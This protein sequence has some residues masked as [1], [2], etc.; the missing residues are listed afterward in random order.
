MTPAFR[1][2]AARLPRPG[3]GHSPLA[4]FFLVLVLLF[5]ALPASAQG[6]TTGTPP[7][8]S[9]A[10][11]PD[12]INIANLNAHIDVPV[13]NKPGRGLNFTYDLSYDSS[14]W[15]PVGAS[16]SQTWQPTYNFGWRGQ[17]EAATGYISFNATVTFCYTNRNP[18]GTHIVLTNWAYHGPWGDTHTFVGTATEN[19]GSCGTINYNFSATATDGSGYALT[20]N[21]PASPPANV[22]TSAGKLILPPANATSGAGSGTDRNGNEIT[23][24]SGGVFTDTLGTTAL[25]VAGTAPSPTTFTYTAPS[26]ASA[27]Y[28]MKY[29]ALTIQT[30]FA[31]SGITDYGPTSNDLVTEIDLPDIAVNP[32]DKYTFTYEPTPGVSGNVT[33]RL[34]SV[35]L[36]TGGKISYTYTGGSN[37][38]V[39]ADGS[40]AGMQ[41][42]TPDTGNSIYWNYARTAG[43]GAAYITT[44]TDPTGNDTV[45][46]FQGIYETER[47]V[48][49]GS[50]TSGTLLRSWNTCYNAS[51]SPCTGTAITLPITQRTVIDQY[52]SAGVQCKHN[53]LYNSV[54][55][56]TEQDDYDYGPSAPGALLRK[57]LITFA[58]LSNIT[59]F[60]QQVTVQNGA[61]AIVAQTNY[62]YDETT[63]TATSGVAQHIS[64][65]GSR[66]NL[67]SINYPVSGLT[68]HFTYYDTGSISS[69]Q[70]VNSATTT[71]NYSST[72]NA[73]CQMAFPT[74]ISEPLSL[75]KSFTWNCT[76]GVPTQATDENGQNV[77][78]SFT[79]AD[80]WRPA[81]VTDQT[82][83]ATNLTY[84][85]QTALEA[86][87]NFNSNNSTSD[88][89]TTLDGLGRAH[90][91]QTK[92]SPSVTTFD[93]VENDFDVLGRPSRTTLP[94]SAT[95]GQTTSPSGAGVT[96]TYDA[97]SRP[98]I[99]T[100]SGGGT[101]TYSYSNNDVL[102]AIGPAPTGEHTKQRQL[103]YDSLG[104]LTSVCEITA[105]AAPW[106]GGA[107]T[108]TTSQ[109][110][111]WTKYAYDALGNLLTVTQNAQATAA[112]Q[113]TRTYT[114][115]AMSRLTAEKNP[116][117]AQN[118]TAYTYD[119]DTTCTP[120]AKG[121]LV[122]RI[123]PVGN[124]TCYTYDLLHRTTS[125]IYTGSYVTPSKYFVYDTATVNSIAMQNAKTRLA[126]A[127]TCTPSSC[128]GTKITDAAFSY[129]AR[130]ELTD[131]YE[132]TPHSGTTGA[133]YNHTSAQFWPNGA[134]NTLA[135]PGL[136]TL[137]YAPDGEGRIK[138][139]S[140]STG[141]PPVTAT[142][143]NTASQPTA[144]TL[145]SNDSD[146]FQYDPNTLRLTQ[147]KFNV[148]SQSV[149]G[150]L[151]WNANSSLGS[152]I[153]TDPLNSL[154][155]QNC[156]FAADDL[157]RISTANCGAIWGQNFTY[158]PFGNISKAKIGTSAGT[159]FQPTY[160]ASPSITNRI[161]SLP[162]NFTPTYDANG[163]STNDSFHQ[164]TWDA[165]NRPVSVNGTAVILTYDA[166]GRM[167][168]Q[169]RGTSYTQIVYSPLGTKLAKMNGA[170]LQTGY[171]PLTSGASAVYNS[172]GL[173]Y[174]RHA[175]H[176]GSSRLASTPAQTLYSDTAYSAFGEPY[177]Q[178]NTPDPSFTGQDQDTTSGV[179]DFL[180]R[181]YDP[182][183]SRW[184]SPD[185]AGTASVSIT[186][187]QSFNRYAYVRNRPLILRDRSGL[188][189]EY[190]SDDAH[191]DEVT[192]ID[193]E[194]TPEDCAGSDG[195]WVDE[196]TTVIVNGDDPGDPGG[197]GSG[198]PPG[199]C[200]FFYQD[201]QLLGTQ[202]GSQF[203]PAAPPLTSQDYIQA[204]A[205]GAPTVCGGGV[206]FYAGVQGK[207][208]KIGTGG[209]GG[210]LGEW[211]SN[212]GYSNNGLVEVGGD[213]S[214]VGGVGSKNGVDSFLFIPAGPVGEFGGGVI[215][216]Q[217]VGLYAGT[218]E[219]FP[220][221]VGGGAYLNITSNAACNAIQSQKK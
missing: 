49:Q 172:T 103:E 128:P 194:S 125:A 35:T 59:A 98:H 109:T 16:G 4:T 156:S 131:L 29:S 92:Q 36:P 57:T 207:I 55:G 70:D 95:A 11:G 69:Q 209:F 113:Q 53:Y 118:T 2:L 142:T 189:C 89:L 37:G 191:P 122:K 106:L 46:N 177:A 74:S 186:D 66:G 26:G 71:Y 63:P 94:Y 198:N 85:A 107:C 87:L 52:G 215:G 180:Y 54:G 204:I 143:Y 188:Y 159:T 190:F 19:G 27:A 157:S 214:A 178:S 75:T 120:A 148:G 117:M 206:F 80:F 81:S 96:T 220:I 218:P 197:N 22:Y 79:D 116:E 200:A 161:A 181:K 154:N 48:Y 3:R 160:Q 221:G 170:T 24:S 9:F 175:D 141:Q 18:T 208:G 155:A 99:V 169:A 205:A 137:T 182:G 13:F 134:L 174:Y 44:V 108:Q 68:A 219:T 1:S 203:T 7:F 193:D 163:N 171:V 73:D 39:C 50:S 112:N 145:G 201:G 72:N 184:A 111:Y 17:T 60:R 124:T 86:A 42:Y 199:G 76:G 167:V 165:E 135:G 64:V 133:T 10:G 58:S 47:Q 119:T 56:L 114:Y 183:Q 77:S 104:R 110:G 45:L 102:I 187:P 15:Y 65:T 151:G 12:V 32:N 61:G 202:C 34:A 93:S 121:D 195:V 62:N 192:S 43:T 129:S 28:T 123:D 162:G 168:E 82:N 40:T 30:K 25:T 6:P 105:G 83:A 212:T 38:I 152:L 216:P 100:D 138:T 139:I 90:V 196:N 97:L 14:V 144:V 132:S 130:G 78:A 210:Y 91:Q 164:F 88:Q 217:G 51:A 150:N 213:Y 166:L 5:T 176:L 115:D 101:T 41:R 211:D 158:D 33:G 140:A 153:I 67:T 179:Y 149:V 126:E 84:T 136:P 127:Y 23:V 147:Y 173:A 185:P 31:C 21:L 20:T 8:G 146:A